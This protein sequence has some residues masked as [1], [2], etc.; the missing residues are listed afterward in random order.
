MRFTKLLISVLFYSLTASSQDFSNKGTEF[1]VGYGSH[2]AMYSANGSVNPAGG[3][4][5]MV[6]YFTSD[7][8]A[9]VTVEI[10]SLGWTRTYTVTANQVTTSNTMPKTIGQDSRIT[11]EGKSADRK[12]HV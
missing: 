11:D 6:L 9:N 3:G 7:R 1:W 4:Q 8:N 12:A 5:D 10:P 2:V